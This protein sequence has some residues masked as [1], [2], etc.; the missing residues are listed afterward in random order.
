MD[1]QQE[2]ALHRL[3]RLW[4]WKHGLPVSLVGGEAP[5]VVAGWKHLATPKPVGLGRQV[6][7]A[8]IGGD[9]FGGDGVG[10]RVL[11][12]GQLLRVDMNA[13]E[14]VDTL[15]LGQLSPD[16]DGLFR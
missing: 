1:V 3:D 10:E 14:P 13:E 6:A 11:V 5:R 12:D 9:S 15:C 2:M 7:V 16:A 8:G 4:T